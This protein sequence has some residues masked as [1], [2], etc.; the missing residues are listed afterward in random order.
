M[1]SAEEL[2]HTYLETHPA[3]A[4]RV[5]ER[6]PAGSAA[7]LL[8]SVPARLGGPVLR[9]MLAPAAARCLERLDDAQAAGLL[10]A[11]GAQGGA[12]LLRFL[13]AT[14]RAHLLAQLPGPLALAYDLL[15]GYPEGTVGAW[16]DPHALALPADLS[17]AEALDALRHTDDAPTAHAYV[18]DARQRLLGQ[19]E[20]PALLRAEAATPLHRLLHPCI[21]RLPAQALA[22]GVATHPGWRESAALPVIDRADHFLGALSHAALQTALHPAAGNRAT[23][24]AGDALTGLAGAYWLG[25]STLIQAIV[26]LLPAKGRRDLP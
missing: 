25:V 16:M 13:S 21:H 17:A 12:A 19:V 20:L 22:S 15:L 5:L 14:R 2:S 9:Q 7:A 26:G 23:M 8:A 10:R 4:A 11:V 24:G 6:L 1:A 3:D 18:I